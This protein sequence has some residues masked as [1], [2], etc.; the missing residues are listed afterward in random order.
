MQQPV[1]AAKLMIYRSNFL[2]MRDLTVP[3]GP[4]ERLSVTGLAHRPSTSMGRQAGA[5]R[6]GPLESGDR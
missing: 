1:T 2:K 6:L 3:A 5:G 4:A